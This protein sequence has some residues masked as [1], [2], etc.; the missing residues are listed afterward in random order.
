MPM[1]QVDSSREL[2]LPAPHPSVVCKP[3]S[4]GAVLLHTESEVYYSLNEVGRQIWDLLP[5]ACRDTAE[6]AAELQRKYPEVELADL[7]KDIAELL[8]SL[9]DEG[10]VVRAG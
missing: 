9:S 7:R 2:T 3:V 4:E 8:Q 1:D 5:P 10:L 6:L